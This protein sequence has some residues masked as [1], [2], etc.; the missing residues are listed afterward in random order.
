MKASCME[1]SVCHCQEPQH[2]SQTGFSPQAVEADQAKG[3]LSSIL[4]IPF[5]QRSVDIT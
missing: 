5:H 3:H 2:L 4:Q 1:A